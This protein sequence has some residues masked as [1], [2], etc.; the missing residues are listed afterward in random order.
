MGQRGLFICI[1]SDLPHTRWNSDFWMLKALIQM[2][3]DDIVHVRT[4][5][6]AWLVSPTQDHIHTPMRIRKPKITISY[7]LNSYS[8]FFFFQMVEYETKRLI[9]LYNV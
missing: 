8:G 6:S 3:M 5:S 1:M 7:F 4:I 2:Q 9:Y